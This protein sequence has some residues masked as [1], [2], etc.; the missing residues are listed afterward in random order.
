MPDVFAAKSVEEDDD[1]VVLL[2]PKR[3][4]VP[5]PV[6]AEDEVYWLVFVRPADASPI[7]KGGIT[8]GTQL[9][10]WNPWADRYRLNGHNVVVPD[11]EV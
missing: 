3:S 1:F 11:P 4:D 5:L 7:P 9:D 8:P 6:S 2:L 10:H